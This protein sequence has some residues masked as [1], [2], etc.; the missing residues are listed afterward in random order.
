L[1]FFFSWTFFI[2]TYLKHAAVRKV[3]GIFQVQVTGDNFVK[4]KTKKKHTHNINM[5]SSVKTCII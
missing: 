3:L 2:E 1:S 4:K 5:Y